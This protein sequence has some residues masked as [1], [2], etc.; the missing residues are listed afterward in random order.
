[1]SKVSLFLVFLL[2]SH[3]FLYADNGRVTHLAWTENPNGTIQNTESNLG[4]IFF[5]Q[6]N[7]F[8]NYKDPNNPFFKIRYTWIGIEW[9]LIHFLALFLTILLQLLTFQRINRKMAESRFFKRWSYRILKLFLWVSVISGNAAIIWAVDYYNTQIHFRYHQLSDF[10]KVAPN[11]LRASLSDRTYFQ[12]KETNKLRFQLYRKAKGK[13]YTQRALPVLH[14][15]Q[16]SKRQIVYQKDTR[17]YKLHPD[18]SRVKATTQLIA[19][20]QKNK[21]G[22]DTTLFFRFENKQ[23]VPMEAQQDKAQRILL[24]V[25]GYRPV[26]NDQDPEKAL[27]AINNKGLE[28]PRSKNLI[29]TSDLFGY[30]PADKFIAPLIGKFSPQRTL[31]ADGHHSVSTSNHQSLLKFISS[32]A[33]YPKPCLGTHHCSTTKIAN[34]QEVRTYSLLATVPNYVGFRKRYLSGQQAGRNLLQELS[35]NGNL[36]LNDTLFAVSHSMGH[37]YFVGMASILKGKIQ[38]GA[39]YAF[40]PENPKGKTFKTKDWQ[41]VYQYG[42]KLYG[43]QR[44]APCHQDGVAPQWRMSGLKE[45]Q[46]ISFPKSRSKRLGYFSSHYIGYYDWVFD[47]PKGQAGFLGRP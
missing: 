16:N 21:S 17:Y 33:L 14:L 11:N 10:K 36:T 9:T 47:I 13:W 46:Q 18:S 31:F 41:A 30:W 24:F 5:E 4:L 32:A 42:T 45:N 2:F 43:N 40:A 29:Y 1:M 23:L 26:S 27:Q 19:L 38:F 8:V 6:R 25:N 37:A 22:T 20:H 3:S 39:Y 15:A 34:Q 28:N 7:Q 35:K 12:A 44:H